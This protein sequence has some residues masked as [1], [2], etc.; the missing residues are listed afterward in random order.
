TY[1]ACRSF[2]RPPKTKTRKENYNTPDSIPIGL[3]IGNAAPE[4]S[5]KNPKDSIINLSSLHGYYVLIDFWASWC[6]PCRLEN[7]RVVK[8]YRDF[9]NK[10]FTNGKGFKIYNVS[11]DMNAEAWKRAIIADSLD[12]PYHVSD[13]KGWNT[14]AGAKYMVQS[15]PVNWL[16]DPKG[17]IIAKGLRGSSLETKLMEYIETGE[18]KDKK[19]K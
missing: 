11:L 4:L 12:W 18:V 9:K 2:S 7:P 1:G 8:A 19:K 15:I 10:T 13:L 5:F 14:E 3:K 6:G 17:I 16:V